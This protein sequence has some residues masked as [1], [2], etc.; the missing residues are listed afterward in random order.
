MVLIPEFLQKKSIIPVQNLDDFKFLDRDQFIVDMDVEALAK[1]AGKS[2][3]PPSNSNDLDANEKTFLQE[4]KQNA[5]SARMRLNKSLSQIKNEIAKIDLESEKAQIEN[6]VEELT[7]ELTNNQE[8]TIQELNKLKDNAQNRRSDLERFRKDNGL[9]REPVYKKSY[10]GTVATIMAFLVLETVLNSTL[11]AEA[12]DLG[13]V[14][15]IAQA[16]IISLINIVLGLSLGLILYPRTNQKNRSMSLIWTAAL[17]LGFSIIGVFNLMVGHYR[18]ALIID[19]DSSGIQAINN[20][21]SGMFSL[22]D[23]ESIFLIAIGLIVASISYWKGS[24]Q[25]DR[26]FGYTTYA[27]ALDSA[28]EELEEE[29]RFSLDELDEKGDYVADSLERVYKKAKLD[30]KN[31][32]LLNSA[33]VEQQELYAAYI[34]DLEST[35][36]ITITLYR[37]NNEVSRS[38]DAPAYF[39][40]QI[41]TDFYSSPSIPSYKD[42]GDSLNEAVEDFARRLPAIKIELKKLI[43]SYRNKIVAVDK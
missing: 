2:N 15:G 40:K 5:S 18:E 16:M 14:G 22:S 42:I 8:E 13:L 24:T 39:K 11:L 25:N 38:D 19:P 3:L 34:E 1:K 20:F 43:E 41:D 10:L 28:E 30:L 23:I 37:Q 31:Y 29:K 27:K 36:K 35:S 33:F 17:I 21:A 12:S 7:A 32:N 26:F 9:T 6:A 4:L